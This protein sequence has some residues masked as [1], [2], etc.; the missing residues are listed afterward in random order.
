MHRYAVVIGDAMVDSFAQATTCAFWA[1]DHLASAK[2]YF[3]LF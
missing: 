3:L 1:L 2:R